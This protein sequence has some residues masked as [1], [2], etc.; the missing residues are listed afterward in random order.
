MPEN[1][2]EEDSYEYWLACLHGVGNQKKRYLRER[3]GGAAKL[4]NI[5]ETRIR[6]EKI[7]DDKEMEA[8]QK[9]RR[10]WK[11]KEN[12]ERFCEGD[13]RFIP[14]YSGEY[15]QKLKELPAMPYAL[16][17][18]GR[19]PAADCPAAAI[20]GAR[21]CS[22]YGEQMALSFGEE[23]AKNGF[24]IV[25][26]MAKGV[27]GIAHR[28]ALNGGGLTYAVLGC[29]PDICYPREN[30]GLYRDIL[31]KGGILSEY[32]PG[33]MPLP[34]HFPARNRIIS[35]LSDIVL[36]IEARERSGSLITADMALEQ[37]RD[38]YALPGPVTSELSRGCNCLIKQGAEVLLSP[39]ELLRESGIWQRISK[40][41]NS[42]N[43]LKNKIMLESTE[44]L[45]Y[46]KLDLYPK[47]KE[48]ILEET[49]LGA[50]E[51]IKALVALELKGYIH[52]ISK[53]YYVRHK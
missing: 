47:S 32:P 35:G 6:S 17:V 51:V 39:D 12:Y 2:R 43:S 52:E 24:I 1:R 33:T 22:G 40:S 49:G 45:V 10:N 16:F 15:P 41:D 30:K 19:L 26:G 34:I 38:V 46:S 7:L 31:K 42:K 53:N 21:R 18:K 14:Y 28:G 13:I 9:S 48:K 8:F 4:Y 25:S 20:V 50:A 3:W 5:E 23:L 29:G 36:V 37:G 27:D 44:N 11:I